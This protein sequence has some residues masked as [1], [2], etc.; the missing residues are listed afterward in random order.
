MMKAVT[1]IVSQRP[2]T[3][4]STSIKLTSYK[5]QYH[6][7][8]Q[9][10]FCLFFP[11]FKKYLLNNFYM[12]GSVVGTENRLGFRFY[13]AYY[14]QMGRREVNYVPAVVITAWCQ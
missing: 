2:N 6:I 7:M 3:R 12:S 14:C 11:H 4:F 8:L 13:G 9:T 5:P 1:E 10:S